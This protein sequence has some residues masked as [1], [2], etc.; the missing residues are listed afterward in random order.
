M[1]QDEAYRKGFFIAAFRDG[2]AWKYLLN[3]RFHT[4]YGS[5]FWLMEHRERG[6]KFY[7]RIPLNSHFGGKGLLVS[8]VS[9]D[10]HDEALSDLFAFLKQKAIEDQKPFIR[11]NLHN[12]T[13][14]A[15]KAI[16]LGATQQGQSAW[17]INIPDPVRF[18]TRIAPVLEKR[19]GESDLKGFTG[20]F[21]LDF[22]KTN[23]DLL[24]EGGK[25]ITIRP[26]A[27]GQELSMRIHKQL[28][29]IL[30]LGHRSWSEV[31]HIWPD[32]GPNSE[33]SAHLVKTLFPV[34]R[35]WLYEPA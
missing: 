9:E 17:Q 15:Q 7:C 18:L 19:V 13:G 22:F 6:E 8:E 25:L 33:K 14:A 35:S 31:A 16:A 11:F 10:I 28:F 21:R 1:K 23:H 29:P 32:V 2:A 26:G 4:M 30:C 24:W 34:T 27:G 3:D 12:D 20:T 5:E